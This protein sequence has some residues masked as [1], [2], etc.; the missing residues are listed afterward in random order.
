MII[1]EKRSLEMALEFVEIEIIDDEV[2]R[3]HATNISGRHEIH[4]YYNSPTKA[5]I[6]AYGK[7]PATFLTAK[8]PYSK[9]RTWRNISGV[10]SIFQD[11]WLEELNGIAGISIR[12]MCAGHNSERL[13]YIIFNLESQDYDESLKVANSL[14]Q[15]PEVKAQVWDS[16]GG[17][18]LIVLTGKMWFG[19]NGWN[20]WWSSMPETIKEC[21]LYVHQQ[22]DKKE[23]AKV[24]PSGKKDGVLIKLADVLQYF[25]SFYFMEPAIYLTGGIVNN[26]ETT[27]D[28]EIL[29]RGLEEDWKHWGPI[30]FRIQRMFPREVWSRVHLLDDKYHGPFT[31]NI[32]LFKLKAETYPDFDISQMQERTPRIKIESARVAKEAADSRK[33]DEI[34]MFR[35]FLPLKGASGYRE[36]ERYS[37][38]AVKEAFRDKKTNKPDP[39]R[40]PLIVQKK[41]DGARNYIF[42]E[43]D[44]VEIITEEG[45]NVTRRYPETIKEL[46]S[47]EHPRS[48]ILDCEGEMWSGEKHEGREYMAAY[49]HSK[50]LPD[51]SKIVFNCFDCLFI[52]DPT[53]SKHDLNFKAGDLHKES[54]ETRLRYLNEIPFRQSTMDEPD[55]KY[56]LNKTPSIVCRL[57]SQLEAAIKKTSTDE[58]SEGS[59]VK[60]AK[61]DY[62]LTGFTKE[63]IKFKKMAELHAIIYKIFPTKVAG[64]YNYG[65]ALKVPT[66]QDAEEKVLIEIPNKTGNFMIIGKSY[67]T[68]TKAKIGQICTIS[69]HTLNLYKN[70]ETGKFRL[71]VY[72]PRWYELRLQQ[73]E[74]D[75][76]TDAIATAKEAKLL[77]TKT[78]GE[79]KFALMNFKEFEEY[80][81]EDSSAGSPFDWRL[82]SLDPDEYE[83]WFNANAEALFPEF[84]EFEGDPFLESPPETGIYEFVI[85]HHYRGASFHIDFRLEHN[86][87]LIG[88]TLMDQKEGVIKESVDTI[89]EAKLAD[90]DL[91][92]ISKVNNEPGMK[93][94]KVLAEP[95]ARQPKIWLRLQGVTDPGEVG[96]TREFP[97]IFNIIDKGIVEYGSQ[98]TWFHEY[99]IHGTNFDGRWVMR[100][101]PV[102]PGWERVGE[103][104]TVWMAWKAKDPLPYVLSA[105]TV[106]DGWMPPLGFS[107]LPKETRSKILDEFQYWKSK[108]EEDAKVKR[109]ALVDWIKSEHRKGRKPFTAFGSEDESDVLEIVVGD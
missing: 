96:G 11:E 71:H 35:Y 98:K 55:P 95:K 105:D 77:A 76:T 33:E 3:H 92:K 2:D 16:R 17:R 102:A 25:K 94:V 59:M 67:S 66:G 44:R 40:Y 70:P 69:Y 88:W 7:E 13:A 23:L 46:K 31:S 19:K 18:P 9:T 20:R 26:G 84:Y 75:T 1:Q 49:A 78:V 39:E 64:V 104:K 85:Q 65:L 15:L 10:D 108:E 32:P 5:F 91:G 89:Q 22:D 93:N 21:L 53:M 54:Q 72:E 50:S 45:L 81:E 79:K 41:Y 6:V 43:G 38:D 87:W 27:G 34:K 101:L 58:S 61:G 74:P 103:E 4:G 97:G 63:I 86:S 109:D 14:S 83:E 36:G 51:D 29:Y 106:R 8:T 80:F 90:K 60:S 12:A 57:E 42:K 24:R 47:I 107:A 62:P 100:K 37:I 48:F 30:L 52:E 68:K 99:W 56:R 82:N 73:T 28:V